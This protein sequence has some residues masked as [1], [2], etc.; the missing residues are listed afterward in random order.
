VESCSNKPN[1]TVF[2]RLTDIAEDTFQRSVVD[3]SGIRAELGDFS[4]S[5][6]YVETAFDI[7][8]HDFADHSAIGETGSSL[9]ILGGDWIL[10]TFRG[11]KFVD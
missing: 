6:T 3:C 4:H 2:T 1:Q 10:R 7:G 5:I 8:E 9:N 11:F